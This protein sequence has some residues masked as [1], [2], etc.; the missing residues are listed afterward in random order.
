MITV[1]NLETLEEQ[2]YS[3]TPEQAVKSAYALE[4]NLATQLACNTLKVD[5]QYGKHFVSCGNW[6]A[7]FN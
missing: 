1:Y 4:N 5:V 7:K 6:T 3:C 2:V